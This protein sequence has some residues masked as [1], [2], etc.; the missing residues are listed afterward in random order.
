MH[1]TKIIKE[2]LLFFLSLE[3]ALPPPSVSSNTAKMATF[4]LSL[5]FF[6][7]CIAVRDF[8]YFLL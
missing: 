6:S 7:L 4:L 3:L 8:A 2:G 5:S 1:G